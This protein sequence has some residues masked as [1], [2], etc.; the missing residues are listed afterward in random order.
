MKA[1]WVA[2][3]VR[4][5]KTSVPFDEARRA[6][7]A[8]AKTEDPVAKAGFLQSTMEKSVECMGAMGVKPR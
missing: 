3:A 1:L 6:Y 5:V 7:T 2:N 8:W 4:R